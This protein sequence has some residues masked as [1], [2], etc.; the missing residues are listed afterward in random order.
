[1][2]EKERFCTVIN[3]MDGRTQRPVLDFLETHFE[4]DHVDTITEPGPVRILAEQ[5]PAAV[6]N[7]ILH[8]LKVSLEKHGSVGV[9]LVIHHDCAG[10]PLEKDGQFLQ[11]RKA[12]GF[13]GS[14]VRSVPV[15]GLWVGED[16]SVEIVPD[17]SP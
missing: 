12:L 10:N 3:C 13:L 15:I 11:L 16:W 7:N 5:T 14:T 17:S 2:N 8:R 6:L 1:M 4:A 9:A